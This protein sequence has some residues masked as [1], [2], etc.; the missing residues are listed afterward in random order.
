[1]KS[2]DIADISDNPCDSVAKRCGEEFQRCVQC[3]SCT[4]GC[5]YS[6][7][8]I[9]RPNGVIRLVQYGHVREV[10][11]SPDIWF[12]AGCNA[13]TIACPMAIDIPEVM[14]ALR[15]IAM[16]SGVEINEKGVRHFHQE[17]LNALQRKGQAQAYETIAPAA[18]L[19]RQQNPSCLVP[20]IRPSHTPRKPV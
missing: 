13:C 2:D 10:L 7:A 14:D 9:Y 12:C 20:V 19:S 3:L 16:E 17:M 5:P 8:M 18:P 4:G 6:Q 1:M 11:E 15:E